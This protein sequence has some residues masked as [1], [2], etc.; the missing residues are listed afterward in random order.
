M[1][2]SSE[3]ARSTVAALARRR[4]R[5]DEVRAKA[6]V[7]EHGE[8]G[9]ERVALKDH[10]ALGAGTAD[11]RA[12]EQ[13]PRRWSRRR[14][15]RSAAAR[16]TCRS[17]DGPSS[18]T[19]RLAS[20]LNEVGDS[21]ATWPLL[22]AYVLVSCRSSSFIVCSCPTSGR[23]AWLTARNSK[24][25]P[26]PIMPSMQEVHPD[27]GRLQEPR[28]LE[29]AVAEA[30]VGRDELGHH[31]VRPRPTVAKPERVE[32]ARASPRARSRAGSPR[33][34]APRACSSPAGA[35]R[36]RGASRRRPSARAERTCRPR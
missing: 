3:R 17:P 29:H 28:E 26:R 13:A 36:A 21:A 14:G 4:R 25:R 32:D 19:K 12:V 24:S 22:P 31:E 34:A 2:S 1:S 10:A 15:R 33:A 20:T 35:R 6:R 5:F 7:L 18:V 11:A 16:S 27:L 8:P 30:F 23:D 9:K